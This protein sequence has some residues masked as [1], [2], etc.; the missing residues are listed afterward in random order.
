VQRPEPVPSYHARIAE[1]YQR[2]KKA[3]PFLRWAGGKQPFLLRFGSLLPHF[4]GKYIEPFL[5]SGAVFFYLQRSQARP[6]LS[7]L[8]DSNLQLIRTFISVKENP[9]QVAVELQDL[10]TGY[11]TS[12]DKVEY[13]Q[14]IRRSYND[15]LPRVNAAEFIFL[16]KT[17]WN[18]LYRVNRAGKFNVPFGSPRP[19]LVVP[20][21]EDLFNV[22]A[23][24][25]QADLQAMS[26]ENT[27]AHADPGD[28]VFLDP[29]YYS[30]VKASSI[31]Y[32]RGQF[33][34]RDHYSLADHLVTLG[35]R[36]ILFVLTNSAEEEMRE[37]YKSRALP[38]RLVQVPRF[39][40]SK[41]DQRE[42]V[43][44]LIISNCL[45]DEGSQLILPSLEE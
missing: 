18:G 26:W 2:A 21:E 44:E 7:I 25:A 22:A 13:Y 30:D 3:R 40:S 12:L 38:T 23:A 34:L 29:P 20:T 32:A 15:H 19:E 37:L 33:G 42:Q 6:F 5:G 14:R 43:D 27:I 16:N 35:Q 39:I 1:W 31:K 9:S 8:G 36:G 17:C 4:Q 45:R 11:N 10:L 41:T 28:M 24:L